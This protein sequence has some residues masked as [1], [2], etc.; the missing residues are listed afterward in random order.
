MCALVCTQRKAEVGR[1]VGFYIK[2][3][4]LFSP[5]HT[6]FDAGFDSHPQPGQWDGPF[7]YNSELIVHSTPSVI[8]AILVAIHVQI[9]CHSFPGKLYNI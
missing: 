4:S 8:L 7:L 5:F 9:P 2:H 6:A 1:D 3:S